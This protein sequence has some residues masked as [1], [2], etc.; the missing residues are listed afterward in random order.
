ML[1][2]EV[3]KILIIGHVWPEPSTTA[4]GK[5][6][7]QLINA[8]LEF[9]Y[10]VTFGCVAARTEH[11]LDLE[12]MGVKQVALQLNHASFDDFIQDLQ[13]NF[14]VFD[15]FMT[16]EQ[17]GWRVAEFAPESV[18]ILN[19]EDLHSL[20]KSREECFKKGEELKEGHWKNHPITLREVSSIY[21]SDLTLMISSFEM[22]LL[23]HE[24]NVPESLLKYLPFMLNAPREE[25][26]ACW[27]NFDQR[28]DFVCVGNGKHPPNVEAI[29]TLKKTI[30]HIIRQRLPKA[31]L[32]IYGAYL[33]QQVLEMHNPKEGFVVKGWVED[34]NAVLQSSRVL[35]APIQFGAGIKGKLV[36][37]MLNGTPSITTPIGAEGMHGDFPW[38]G[39]I[40]TDWKSFA[41][42]AIELY[43]DT[44]K[45]QDAQ[46]QGL[47]ILK[48][49]FPKSKIQSSLKKDLEEVQEH[50]KQRRSD[51]LIGRILQ[52]QGLA[53][54]KYMG[55]WIEEKNKK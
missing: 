41:Q 7:M 3:N 15:R 39:A 18:R 36:D 23:T 28:R 4:A 12:K 47:E 46:N 25:Q 5:R 17:F 52:Q 42:S 22:Q 38:A 50:L 31:K 27:P 40:C 21:R 48:N 20:R 6:M 32:C 11:S 29:G 8:F 53:A 55:K 1:L 24:A 16:E 34:L 49:Q 51:N 10:D 54:T 19:T 37:A 9:G 26:L 30:W 44:S 43:T 45:W 2:N 35:L 33:P 13:P 14:V